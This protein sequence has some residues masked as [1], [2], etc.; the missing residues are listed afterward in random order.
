MVAGMKRAEAGVMEA[1]MRDMP[2]DRLGRSEEVAASAVWLC[3][4]AASFV[5]GHALAVDGGY[6]AC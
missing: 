6:V 4:P 3:S 2:I 5:V 1:M